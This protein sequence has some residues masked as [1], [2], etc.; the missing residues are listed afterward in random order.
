MLFY[1]AVAKY[2]VK[3][4]PVITCKASNSSNDKYDYTLCYTQTHKY[5]NT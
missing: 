1:Y 2:L 4:K 5:N 3:L